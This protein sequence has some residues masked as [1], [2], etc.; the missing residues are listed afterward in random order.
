MRRH[1]EKSVTP[2][3]D[4]QYWLPC[5]ACDGYTRHQVLCQVREEERSEYGDITIWHVYE[6]VECQG[7]LTTCLRLCST[8]TED[9]GE[10]PTTGEMELI[11][12]SRAIS[13]AGAGKETAYWP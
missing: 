12:H 4:D 3:P 1:L 6:I 11:P 8:S 2:S 10:N 9:A 13:Q 7:C 5:S